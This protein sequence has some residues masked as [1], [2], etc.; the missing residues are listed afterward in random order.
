MF[1]KRVL[2]MIVILL[3]VGAVS[4]FAQDD[5]TTPILD[6]DTPQTDDVFGV[7]GWADGIGGMYLWPSTQYT[8]AFDVWNMTGGNEAIKKI[9]ITLPDPT[10]VLD[11]ATLA[12]PAALIHEGEEAGTW[13]VS[14]DDATDTLTWLYTG[15]T[16][17]PGIGNI[18]E[19]EHVSLTFVATTGSKAD[20]FYG[21][22]WYNCFDYVLTGDADPATAVD[23]HYCF[24]EPAGGD[25]TVDEDDDNDNDSNDDD[26]ADSDNEDSDKGCGC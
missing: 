4:A 26:N 3:L 5:D 16:A 14:F 25:D 13:A 23:D 2:M 9:A 17:T 10:C 15:P 11:Q 1:G 7:I 19:S 18:R 24:P 21:G 8:F 20:P 12:A 6:D 22:Y